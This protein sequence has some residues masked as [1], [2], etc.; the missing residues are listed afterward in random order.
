MENLIAGKKIEEQR[1][2]HQVPVLTPAERKDTAEQFLGFATA[3]RMLLVGCPLVGIAGRN[4]HADIER[5]GEIQECGHVLSGMPVEYGGVH[6]DCESARLGGADRRYG[7]VKY[8]LLRH[9][10]VVVIAQ[11]VEVDGE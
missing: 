4:R 2:M 9:R 11:P 1:R 8:A 5:L 3:E 6:V 10:L 7:A